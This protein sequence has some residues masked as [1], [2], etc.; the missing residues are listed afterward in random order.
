MRCPPLE[1]QK[2]ALIRAVHKLLTRRFQQDDLKL[3]TQGK[4]LGLEGRYP[5]A[6]IQRS[7]LEGYELGKTG[8]YIEPSLM[9]PPRH[10]GDS[11]V[12]GSCSGKRDPRNNNCT[13]S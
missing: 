12:G 5:L 2:K 1:L 6:F 4:R 8:L 9:F 11:P 7:L 3:A 10:Q 13:H